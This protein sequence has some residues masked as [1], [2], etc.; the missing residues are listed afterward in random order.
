[1]ML[2]TLPLL[3][4]AGG[5]ACTL[6]LLLTLLVR[7]AGAQNAT[8]LAIRATSPSFGVGTASS[9]TVTVANEGTADTDADIHVTTLLPDGLTFVTSRGIDWTCSAAG[10]Q[11]DCVTPAALGA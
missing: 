5:C 1:M 8:D 3:R 4:H 6:T 9:Y 10:Q 11:V 7:A 2:N